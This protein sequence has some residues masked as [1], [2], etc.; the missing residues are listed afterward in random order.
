MIKVF[1]FQLRDMTLRPAGICYR[2]NG[3]FLMDAKVEDQELFVVSSLTGDQAL[4][5]DDIYTA[6]LSAC[7]DNQWL[8][9]SRTDVFVDLF[10]KLQ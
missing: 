9:P 8:T 10:T 5:A 7:A 6:V 4:L 3:R 1:V 2:M